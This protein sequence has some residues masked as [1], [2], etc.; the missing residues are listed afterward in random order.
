M[1]ENDNV[2][3]EQVLS[4]LRR[5]ANETGAAVLL[6]HHTKKSQG[7]NAESHAGDAEAGRGASALVYGTR[8]TFTLAK[9]A[10]DTAKNKGI[11]PDLGARLCRGWMTAVS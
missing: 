1:A 3:V 11:E 5:I 2:A 6:I 7:G 9:M 10:K 4:I 8:V